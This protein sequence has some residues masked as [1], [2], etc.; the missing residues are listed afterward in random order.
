M[1]SG[2]HSL[3][4]RVSIR[5]TTGSIGALIDGKRTGADDHAGDEQQYRLDKYFWQ[6]D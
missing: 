5:D 4:A 3:A 6:A 1:L 2:L